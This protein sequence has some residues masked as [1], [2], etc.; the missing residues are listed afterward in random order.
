M[1][2]RVSVR[3][4]TREV[5]TSY[6]DGTEQGIFWMPPGGMGWGRRPG[7]A[8]RCE[9]GTGDKQASLERLVAGC[10]DLGM[11]ERRAAVL[12]KLPTRSSS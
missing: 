2:K 7:Q 9:G 11:L 3:E 10:R 5:V 8:D 4:C 1:I 6:R 12:K